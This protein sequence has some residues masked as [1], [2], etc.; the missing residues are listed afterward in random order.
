MKKYHKLIIMAIIVLIAV[1]CLTS[2]T[3]D[4]E[5]GNE[6]TDTVVYLQRKDYLIEK[7]IFQLTHSGAGV[8]GV[9]EMIFT[10]KTQRP[11]AQDITV[12]LAV[13]AGE[14]L[15]VDKLLLTNQQ[16]VIKAGSIQSEE[17]TISMSD[18]AFMSTSEDLVNYSFSVSIKGIKTE[19]ANTRVSNSMNTLSAIIEKSAFVNLVMGTPLD[20]KLIA[21]RSDWTLAVEEG[22]EGK[23]SNLIDGSTTDVA[24]NNIGFWITVDLG[25]VKTV[26]GIKTNHWSGSYAPTQVEVFWSADGQVWKSLGV[27]KTSGGEQNITFISKPQTRF[28]KYNILG[29]P[30]TNRVD[31]TE[32]NVYEA[33]AK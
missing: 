15:D 6:W 5:A 16:V 7:K 23:A 32:F 22:V 9:V 25:T 3:A 18:F 27:I 12:D 26:T 1:P 19:G 28:I 33:N 17:V 29:M 8:S 31:V 24:R 11:A 10:V 14:G 20:S 13:F 21:N 4:E 2:C 30:S